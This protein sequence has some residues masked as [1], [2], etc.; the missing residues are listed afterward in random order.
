MSKDH[1]DATDEQGRIWRFFGPFTLLSPPTI[2]LEPEAGVEVETL[3]LFEQPLFDKR[4]A[5]TEFAHQA[6]ELPFPFSPKD[7]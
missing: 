2:E 6:P 7:D 4:A 3:E 1:F 5:H